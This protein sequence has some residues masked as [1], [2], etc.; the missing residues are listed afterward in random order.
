MVEVENIMTSKH[1][2]GNPMRCIGEYT[3]QAKVSVKMMKMENS[4]ELIT[5]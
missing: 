3:L 1:Q 4:E 5:A 2:A